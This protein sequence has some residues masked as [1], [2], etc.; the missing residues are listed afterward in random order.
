MDM[1]QTCIGMPIL[2]AKKSL[3]LELAI[4]AVGL[5]DY[6]L[7]RNR[8]ASV[9]ESIDHTTLKNLYEDN[10]NHGFSSYRKLIRH[11]KCIE[12]ISNCKLILN[13]VITKK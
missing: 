9:L 7:Q 13:G 1:K 11:Y 2:N 10:F 6:R 12:T 8:K 5:H 4:P 3:Y